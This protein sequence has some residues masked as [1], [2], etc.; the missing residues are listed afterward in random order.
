MQLSFFKTLLYQ[1][2]NFFLVK[3]WL[4]NTGF[5]AEKNINAMEK[6]TLKSIFGWASSQESNISTFCLHTGEEMEAGCG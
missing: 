6:S 5:K 1:K 3:T 2:F 4:H